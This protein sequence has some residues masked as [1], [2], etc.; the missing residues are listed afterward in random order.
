MALA[1]SAQKLL[2]KCYC[3]NVARLESLHTA[4]EDYPSRIEGAGNLEVLAW[5]GRA[6]S[7]VS[8]AREPA[9][10]DVSTW[11]SPW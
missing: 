10:Q 3:R 11:H 5:P 9:A 7:L 2:T 8:E 1:S 6:V 4:A